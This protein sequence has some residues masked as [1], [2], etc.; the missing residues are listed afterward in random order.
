MFF[1][2]FR[3]YRFGSKTT[4]EANRFIV[5]L[6]WIGVRQDDLARFRLPT[7][8]LQELT[9]ADEAKAASLSRDP[10]VAAD[11]SLAQEA[12]CFAGSG[13]RFK[14]EVE[15]VFGHGMGFLS[16]TFLPCKIAA[17][18]ALSAAVAAM[19]VAMPA[20]IV[21]AECGSPVASDTFG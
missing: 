18:G 8:S 16:E 2:S 20:A 19:S 11:P 1:R 17:S 9:L 5:P 4:P 12:A 10:A 21:L 6:Q 3:C 14:M 13:R 15:G 7:S